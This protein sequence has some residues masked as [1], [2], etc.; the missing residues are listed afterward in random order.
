MIFPINSQ[1]K[2]QL[3]QQR[4]E[5][6]AH[7]KDELLL[8]PDI[9]GIVLEELAVTLEELQ[10][11]YEMLIDNQE[12]A[13]QERLHYQNLFEL[14]P[15]CYL[16]TNRQ[17]IIEEAN[18]AVT[19]FFNMGREFLL[20]KPLIVLVAESDRRRLAA[21][22]ISLTQRKYWDLTFKPRQSEPI[23][24]SVITNSIYDLTGTLIRLAW[25]F[26]DPLVFP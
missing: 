8:S 1:Q 16:V 4:V 24:A 3:A 13:E 7:R 9:L 20:G 22:M 10:V 11:Q 14:A 26:R 12:K 5:I 6:L 15:E 21:E 18:Q 19:R 2:L 23:V 25:S 17:G